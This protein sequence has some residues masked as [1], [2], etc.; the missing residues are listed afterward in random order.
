MIEQNPLPSLSIKGKDETID[1]LTIHPDIDSMVSL[2]RNQVKESYTLV[3]L[4]KDRNG[5]DFL[6][7]DL[8][9]DGNWDVKYVPDGKAKGNYI[10]LDDKWLEVE[11]IEGVKS[12]QPTF[13]NGKTRFIFDG[14]WKMT[15]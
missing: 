11:E 7:R 5:D 1:S 6:L 2:D 9:L 3:L 8:N 4:G 10:R 13:K 14:S 12:A 15:L